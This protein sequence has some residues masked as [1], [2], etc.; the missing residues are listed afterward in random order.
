MKGIRRTT[1]ACD[2]TRCDI[3]IKC[4][5]VDAMFGKVDGFLHCC[6]RACCN[7]DGPS[8]LSLQTLLCNGCSQRF[9]SEACRVEARRGGYC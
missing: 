1:T 3:T 2:T 4:S 5:K 9:C 6:N 7:L 8:E